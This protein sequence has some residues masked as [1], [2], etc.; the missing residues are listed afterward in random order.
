VRAA[1]CSFS[2]PQIAEEC[3]LACFEVNIKFIKSVAKPL[4]KLSGEKSGSKL[5][6]LQMRVYGDFCF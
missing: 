6:V 4:S 1:C 3:F 2:S 5:R